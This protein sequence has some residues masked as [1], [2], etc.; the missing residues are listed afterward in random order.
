MFRWIGL[1]WVG[2]G[3]GFCKIKIKYKY[4][5]YQ[6][7]AILIFVFFTYLFIYNKTSIN[8]YINMNWLYKSHLRAHS[9]QVQLAARHCVLVTRHF[10][11][12]SV[13]GL[14]ILLGCRVF[15][16]DLGIS[17]YIICIFEYS[18]DSYYLY[19]YKSCIVILIV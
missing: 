9:M 3:V 1:G 11:T 17:L 13:L 5:S 10:F 14:C 12:W 19:T 16:M 2:V 18:W 4:C 15:L 6:Y 7:Y 8:S